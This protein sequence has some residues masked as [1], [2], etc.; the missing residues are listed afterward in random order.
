[1]EYFNVIYIVKHKFTIS[2]LATENHL[3][4]PVK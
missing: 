1:M 3:E 2:K 4:F